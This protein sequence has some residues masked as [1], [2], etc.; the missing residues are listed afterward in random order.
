MSRI[1]G[2]YLEQPS[3]LT[4]D[5][6][7]QTRR[8]GSNKPE[9]IRTVR[10]YGYDLYF[11]FRDKQQNIVD[12]TSQN[13]TA[14]IHKGELTVFEKPVINMVNYL[15]VGKITLTQKEMEILDYGYYGIYISYMDG[16]KET[17]VQTADNLFRFTL[18]VS[19]IL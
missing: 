18:Y 16:D 5:T 11:A 15:G 7:A 2:Y 19:R 14:K 1:L 6:N 8:I 3:S 12:L 9:A 4:N 10:G 17:L 13:F